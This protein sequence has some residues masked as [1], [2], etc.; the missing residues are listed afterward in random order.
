[1]SVNT[2]EILP[3]VTST[4]WVPTEQGRKDTQVIPV[5]SKVEGGTTKKV[6]EDKNK[7]KSEQKDSPLQ[8]RDQEFQTHIAE[9]VQ[10]FLDE[11]TNV[12]LK[13]K[14]DS[15]FGETRVQVLDKKSGEVI[16]QIPP[17]SLLEVHSK[18]EELRGILF[19]SKA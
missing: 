19:D 17:E 14:V 8:S 6:G 13:F 12:Q 15:G 11:A 1:M 2:G 5:V 9:K 7:D 4:P 10:E 16:R 3:I 18:L